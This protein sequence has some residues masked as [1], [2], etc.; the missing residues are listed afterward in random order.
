MVHVQRM[1]KESSIQRT[2]RAALD[3]VCALTTAIALERCDIKYA[4]RPLNDVGIH[5]T[6]QVDKIGRFDHRG[7]RGLRGYQGMMNAEAGE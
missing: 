4:T 2:R 3:S 7:Y 1:R 6:F 5:T